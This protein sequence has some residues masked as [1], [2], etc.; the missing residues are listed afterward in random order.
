MICP[1]CAENGIESRMKSDNTRD[2]ITE[3]VKSDGT[4]TR[5]KVSRVRRTR[6]CKSCGHRKNTIEQ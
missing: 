1:A 6:V 4:K 2:I 5:G 3:I